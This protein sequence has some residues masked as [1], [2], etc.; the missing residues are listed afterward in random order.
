MNPHNGTNR[1]PNIMLIH[2]RLVNH[3]IAYGARALWRRSLH[4]SLRTGIS[5]RL[6]DGQQRRKDNAPTAKGGRFPMVRTQRYA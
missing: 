5:N 4:R 6:H 3:G 2:V 1:T